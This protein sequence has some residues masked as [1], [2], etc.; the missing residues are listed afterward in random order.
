MSVEHIQCLCTHFEIVLHKSLIHCLLVFRY[1]IFLL[2]NI[3]ITNLFA[4]IFLSIIH[5][6]SVQ[7]SIILMV[8]KHIASKFFLE[9]PEWFW[10]TILSILY[11]H[12]L[13]WK[14]L[15]EEKCKGFRKSGKPGLT[16]LTGSYA[17]ALFVCL[18]V[19]PNCNCYTRYF[20]SL[21]LHLMVAVLISA[22]YYQSIHLTFCFIYLLTVYT[23]PVC[24][25]LFFCLSVWL[26]S[27]SLTV[28]QFV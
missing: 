10:G 25:Y 28:N 8:C 14:K 22:K 21:S 6:L 20:Q 23:V 18:S 7:L 19:Y 4:F 17:P 13:K 3:T 11:L 2:Q 9:S 16:W 12:F 26:L 15:D 24:Q 1:Y 27:G 5:C